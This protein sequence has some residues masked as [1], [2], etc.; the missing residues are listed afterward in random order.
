MRG[1]IGVLILTLL[2]SAPAWAGD[3][4]ES[5]Y[6][7]YCVSCHGVTG[8]GNGHAQMKVKPIDFR[9][10]AV[11]NATDEELFKAIG[12]GVGHKEY[13]H[14]FA[15]RGLTAKQIGDLVAY[16]RKLSTVPKKSK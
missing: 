11:Q 8:D 7:T 15:E 10:P 2:S 3:D 16:V 14:G 5:T 4:A 12:Y 13:A 6:K 9:S 1:K